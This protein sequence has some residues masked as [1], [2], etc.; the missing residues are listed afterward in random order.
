MGSRCS[1]IAFLGLSGEW[2]VVPNVSTTEKGEGILSGFPTRGTL[3]I[4]YTVKDMMNP[5]ERTVL[6]H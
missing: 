1:F 3:V 5:C 2:E 4:L 6:A